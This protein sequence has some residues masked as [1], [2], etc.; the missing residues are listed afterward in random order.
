MLQALKSLPFV[1]RKSIGC[2]ELQAIP[3]IYFKLDA[4]N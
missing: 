2:L 1:V 4:D 3:L